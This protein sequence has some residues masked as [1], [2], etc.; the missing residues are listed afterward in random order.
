MHN[1]ARLVEA[2]K[3]SAAWRRWSEQHAREGGREWR[4]P[5]RL[6]FPYHKGLLRHKV[7]RNTWMAGMEAPP[8]C[9]RGIC[10]STASVL[11]KA[12]ARHPSKH[13]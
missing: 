9:Q 2:T 10:L 13:S 3:E 11:V 1:D 6:K 7:Q 4:L 8:C 12:C 5:Q